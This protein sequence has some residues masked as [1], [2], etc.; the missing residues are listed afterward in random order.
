MYFFYVNK[1]TTLCYSKL[2]IKVK[3]YNV[4]KPRSQV[5]Q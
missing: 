4:P 2:L 3:V 5:N 1:M